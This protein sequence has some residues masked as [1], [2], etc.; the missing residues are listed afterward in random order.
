[1]NLVEDTRSPLDDYPVYRYADCL[2]LLAQAKA[3]LGEDPVEEINA[4]RKRAYGEDYF[5][6]HPE[7]QYPNDN[8]AALYADNKSV[9][10]DNAGAME[11]VLKERMREFM[12]E[13]KR[14]YDLRLAGDEYVLEH[15][16]AE[17]TRLLW[18]IDKNTLT[19][20]SALKQTPG[21]ESSGG[22]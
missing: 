2:L 11:A 7:V 1:M 22:K 5:N 14:W 19:N 9:K 17:A 8:D 21:Y 3:F 12:V 10:P 18:P 4:V 6:A 16:T 15:T 20:N 13:G